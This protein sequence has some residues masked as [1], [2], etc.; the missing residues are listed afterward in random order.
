MSGVELF[1]MQRSDFVKGLLFDMEDVGWFLLLVGIK[2]FDLKGFNFS[3][4]VL[5]LLFD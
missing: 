3:F 2:T 4:G 5:F 1:M